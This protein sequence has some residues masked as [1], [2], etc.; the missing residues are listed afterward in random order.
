[1]LAALL[2]IMPDGGFA[3]LKCHAQVPCQ[4]TDVRGWIECTVRKQANMAELGVLNGNSIH[5]LLLHFVLQ[6]PQA[7]FFKVQPC[8]RLYQTIRRTRLRKRSAGT[9]PNDVLRK[10]RPSKMIKPAR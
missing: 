9:V 5:P 1:V 8:V 10:R 4:A 2:L 7:R 3:E 6:A